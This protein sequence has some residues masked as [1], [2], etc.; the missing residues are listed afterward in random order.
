[1]QDREDVPRKNCNETSFLEYVKYYQ[2]YLRVFARLLVETFFIRHCA[3]V[4]FVRILALRAKNNGHCL[5]AGILFELGLVIRTYS[6]WSC[7]FFDSAFVRFVTEKYGA[8]DKK[9]RCERSRKVAIWIRRFYLVWIVMWIKC[10]VDIIC[11]IARCSVCVLGICATRFFPPLNAMHFINRA[12]IRFL[13][14]S[15]KSNSS[16]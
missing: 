5:C 13:S 11:E 10:L 6:R 12:Y 8:H 14:H 3:L 7:I 16:K 9:A 2:K 1:M 15:Q 4:I